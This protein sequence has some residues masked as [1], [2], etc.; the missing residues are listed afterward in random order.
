MRRA[1]LAAA[2]G[3]GA[4]HSVHVSEFARDRRSASADT[5]RPIAHGYT[6][7]GHY[8]RAGRDPAYTELDRAS[9][10][11]DSAV[12]RHAHHAHCSELLLLRRMA[13]SCAHAFPR[14]ALSGNKQQLKFQ[15]F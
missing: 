8:S 5:P 9:S 1:Q 4:M 14:R 2:H 15:L 3:A 11:H 7:A 10:F 6:G 12:G 13:L